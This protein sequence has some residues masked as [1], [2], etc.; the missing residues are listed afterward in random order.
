MKN[1]ILIILILAC[2]HCSAQNIYGN[3]PLSIVISKDNT[4]VILRITNSTEDSVSMELPAILTINGS[5]SGVE[6]II[7]N[8][9]GVRYDIC[10][11]MQPLNPPVATALQSKEHA[12]FRI[13]FKKISMVYC[14]EPGEY[15]LT[16]IYHHVIAGEI[17]GPDLVS[18]DIVFDVKQR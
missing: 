10:A 11:N 8:K 5:V 3:S 13:S 4:G 18:S 12:E 1:F 14:P 2:G 6:L 9:R 17:V 7:R 16:A 15:K